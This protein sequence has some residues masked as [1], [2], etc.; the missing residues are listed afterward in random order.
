MSHPPQPDKVLIEQLQQGNRRTFEQ[1]FA[2]RHQQLYNYCQKWVKQPQL[3]EEVVLDVFMTVWK[4]RQQ[5]DPT[6]TVDSFL[7]KITKDLSFNCLKKAVREQRLFSELTAIRIH[8]SANPTEAQLLS[9][10][11]EA[12]AER[13]IEQLPPQRR[14]IFALRRQEGLSYEEIA[15]QLGISKNTVKGQ[16]GKASRFLREYVATHADITLLWCLLMPWF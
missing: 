12:L 3:A 2:D 13:A 6:L 16:L 4:K 11:Y 10:E 5:L 15:Q 1:L 14:I 7:F 8:P 9:E